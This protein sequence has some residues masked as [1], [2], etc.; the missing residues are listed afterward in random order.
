MVNFDAVNVKNDIV[1]WIREWF[2]EN[3]KGCNAVVGISGGK[4]SSVVAALCVEALGKDRVVG[5]LMPNS[6]VWKTAT[7]I[8]EAESLVKHLDI[9]FFK[10]NI[11]DIVNSFYRTIPFRLS[12][13]SAINLPPRIRMTMLY[14]ISQSVNGRVANTCNLSEDW[15]GYS[16]RWGDSVG[17]FSPLSRLTTD[18]VVAVGD[19][20][21]LPY[22]LTHKVPADGLCGKTDEDNLGFT[23]EALNKYIRT[24]ICEDVEVKAKIDKLHEKNLF[25][26]KPMPYYPYSGSQ[27]EPPCQGCGVGW[28]RAGSHGVKTCKETCERFKAY[29]ERK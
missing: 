4:D 18:E 25:K 16:T 1:R 13:Q 2:E 26:L 8:N 7:D 11:Y 27:V 22:E 10:A 6:Y 29:I 24:G 23:Y 14:A 3:G 19:A 9:R 17:D 12:T 20:C 21:G 15:V 5:V 28:G